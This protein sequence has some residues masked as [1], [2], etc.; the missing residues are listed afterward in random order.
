MRVVRGN[1]KEPVVE[2]CLYPVHDS[3]SGLSVSF[4]YQSRALVVFSCLYDYLRFILGLLAFRLGRR[5]P[6]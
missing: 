4:G 3:S 1:W 2:L 6:A 5:W